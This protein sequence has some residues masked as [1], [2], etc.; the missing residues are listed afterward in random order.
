[1]IKSY[2]NYTEYKFKYSGNIEVRCKGG[3]LIGYYK[4]KD[5]EIR[6]T[7]FQLREMAWLL[8]NI[9]NDGKSILDEQEIFSCFA[10]KQSRSIYWTGEKLE[11]T[12]VRFV[13]NGRYYSIDETG[14]LSSGGGV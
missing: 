2:N 5:V 13:C 8:L 10:R 7:G 11:H 4:A 14:K 9:K 6:L 12:H 3:D 1:M